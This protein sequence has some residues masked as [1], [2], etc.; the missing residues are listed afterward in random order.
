[1]A[2]D[3]S[4]VCATS[5]WG[6]WSECSVQCGVGVSTR[7]RYFINPMGPKKCPLVDTGEYGSTE[8][9]EPISGNVVITLSRATL[10]LVWLSNV[11]IVLG[12]GRYTPVKQNGAVLS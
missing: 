10:A 1:M 12:L 4:G 5:E 6:P 9:I 11:L 2:V 8:C 7:R 3:T